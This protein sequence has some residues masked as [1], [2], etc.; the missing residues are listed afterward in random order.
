M[1]KLENKQ[2]RQVNSDNLV[3]LA[4]N[5][6]VDLLACIVE[7]HNVMDLSEN[8]LENLENISSMMENSSEN[9]ES[10]VLDIAEKMDCMKE[11]LVYNLVTKDCMKVLELANDCSLEKRENKKGLLDCM[12]EM[13]DC[14]M[15]LSVNKD[16]LENMKLYKLDLLPDIL[17]SLAS[18]MVRKANKTNLESIT[19]MLDCNLEMSV[20]N[21]EMLGCK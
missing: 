3:T 2:P 17:D 11:L 8:N 14:T 6:S 18:R 10:N 4:N 19:E 7:K 1:N 13:L 15:D 20:N 9:L 5:K 16:L 21:V 12:K